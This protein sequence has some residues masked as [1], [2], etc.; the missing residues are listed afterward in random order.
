MG[1]A[2][3][4]VWMYGRHMLP[5]QH[6]EHRKDTPLFLK[7]TG[8]QNTALHLLCPDVKSSIFSSHEGIHALV[9]YHQNEY[10]P[11]YLNICFFPCLIE[12]DKFSSPTEARLPQL[13]ALSSKQ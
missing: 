11:A 13:H 8:Q 1:D 5:D 3:Q 6:P 2:V 12:V 10:L 9:A 4:G 7:N